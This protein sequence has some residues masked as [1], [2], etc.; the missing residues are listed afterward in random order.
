[1]NKIIQSNIFPNQEIFEEIQVL[2]PQIKSISIA[3]HY[4]NQQTENQT[5]L[6][7]VVYES[8][9]ELSKSDA[10]KMKEWLMKRLNLKNIGI[11][12]L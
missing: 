2:F 1:M 9:S 10:S 4:Y 12:K 7:I 3:N 5:I 11:V 6:P 8:E